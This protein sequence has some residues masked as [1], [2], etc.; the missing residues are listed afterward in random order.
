MEDSTHISDTISRVR[1]GDREIILVGTAHISRQSVEEVDAII[2]QEMPE[3]VCVEIDQGRYKSMTEGQNWS[4]LKIGDII[5]QRKG[6]LLLAN[7]ILSSFQRRMGLNLGTKPGEE[8]MKAVQTA[9]ELDIPFS[10]SDREVQVTLRRAWGKS[11]FWNKNKLLAALLGSVFTKEKLTEEEM[12]RLKNRNALEGMLEEL[13][14]VMPSVKEVLIDERDRFLATNIFNTSEKKV[15]AVIGAG[16]APGIVR[17]LND[18]HE[19]KVENDLEDISAA[20][21]PKKIT[22]ITPW[23]IPLIVVGVLALGFFRSG[24]REALSMLWMWVLVNGTLSALGSLIALAHPVTILAAFVAAP[25]TSLNPA[26]GVG[27]VTGLVEAYFRKPRV[28][29]FENLQDDISSFR[30]FYRNRFTRI[31]LVF[32]LSTIGSAIGTFIGIPFITSLLA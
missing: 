10:F 16:H 1:L 9:Q 26:I 24:W 12:E 27:I 29:D 3:R 4:S 17:W 15:V 28:I 13:A 18:L 8:M 25:I 19:G 6:F 7:L 22:K 20:P 32:F 14:H 11:S 23:I 31:L 5:R 21:P 30:G 2:R